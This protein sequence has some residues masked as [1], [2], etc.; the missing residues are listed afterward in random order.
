MRIQTL[1]LALSFPL[2]AVLAQAPVPR[3]KP[4]RGSLDRRINTLLDEAPFDRAQWGVYVIDDQGRVRYQRDGDRY[5]VPASN[6]KL[7]VT[8]TATV[9]LPPDYREIGRASCRER[10]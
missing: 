8:S 9:L 7:V 5:R 2:P 10:V 4:L 6:T 1:L 3:T